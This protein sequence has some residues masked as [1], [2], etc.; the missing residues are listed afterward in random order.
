M[1]GYGYIVPIGT[2]KRKAKMG[3]EENNLKK[4]MGTYCKSQINVVY[5]SF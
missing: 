4:I 2:K 5:Y 1:P 3:S